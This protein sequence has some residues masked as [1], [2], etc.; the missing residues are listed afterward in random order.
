MEEIKKNP[1]EIIIG[2]IQLPELPKLGAIEETIS[3][4]LV[5]LMKDDT[6]DTAHLIKE[7]WGESHNS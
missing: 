6:R 4:V 2:K 7:D 1:I 5:H 3:S